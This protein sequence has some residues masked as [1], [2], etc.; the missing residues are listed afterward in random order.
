MSF[1]RFLASAFSE[2]ST[3]GSSS[4]LLSGAIVMFTLGWVTYLVAKNHA[5]P[6]LAGPLT[7][8]NTGVGT[9]MGINKASEVVSAFKGKS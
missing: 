5:M 4:R 3:M 8:M 6:D 9:L 7:F 2:D 1:F